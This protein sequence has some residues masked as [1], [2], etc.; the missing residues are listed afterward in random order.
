MI[1]RFHNTVNSQWKKENV[2][3]YHNSHRHFVTRF[4]TALFSYPIE[5]HKKYKANCTAE[6]VTN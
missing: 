4:L 5:Y 1:Y 6:G 2:A 3:N